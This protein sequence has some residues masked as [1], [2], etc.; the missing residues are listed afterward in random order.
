MAAL[1]EI[2]SSRY[3][4]FTTYRKD[5]TAVATPVWHVS[6]D[7]GELL[8]VS[9]ADAWKVKRLR[10]DSRVVVTICDLRGRI[11]PGAPSA[12]GTARVLD[13]AGTQ[14]ARTLLARK[15]VMSRLGNWVT[16]VLRLRR[17]PVIAIAVTF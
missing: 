4:S 8:V 15:Y 3:V 7:E 11:T 10:R 6:N 14:A 5:G 17:R 2:R 16:K 13:E 12:G 9:E 1:D